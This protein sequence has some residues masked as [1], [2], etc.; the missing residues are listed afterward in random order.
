MV[1]YPGACDSRK[2]LPPLEP[3]DKGRQWLSK[4][5]EVAA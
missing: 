2:I 4:P 5:R 3:K 1:K